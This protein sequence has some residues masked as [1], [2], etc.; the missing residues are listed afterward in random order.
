MSFLTIDSLSRKEK[1]QLIVDNVSVEIKQ[2]QK[3][4][5]AGATGSGK[6]S[7]LRMIAGLVQPSAGE[8]RFNNEKVIGPWDQLIP[9]HKG[10]AYLSQHFELFNNYW[11]HEIL[12]MV[13]QLSEEEA[14]KVYS[15]CRIEHLMN[16]RTHELSGGEKQRIALA[17]QL[18]TSPKLLLLDEPFSNLDAV[19]KS[20][21]KSVIDDI[22]KQLGIT[23]MMV[24]HDAQDILSWADSIFIMKD[25][26]I[27]QQGKPEE[28]YHQPINEYC[29]GLLGEYNLIGLNNKVAM[30]RPEQFIVGLPAANAVKATVQQLSFFGSHYIIHALMQGEDIKIKADNRNVD[31]GQPIFVSLK[32]EGIWYLPSV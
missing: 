1:E 4:A 11:V 16:R 12:E 26:M 10:I 14:N 29:A 2:F 30:I 15:I 25:G 24:S 3:I 27:I 28:V 18:S 19:H 31:I 17:R 8:I 22:G 23:C 20:I 21:I 6:T 5:I 32:E 9:G 13:N 7:L